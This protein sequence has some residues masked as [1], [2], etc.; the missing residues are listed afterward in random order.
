[1]KNSELSMKSIFDYRTTINNVLPIHNKKKKELEQANKKLVSL[2]ENL[3][4]HEKVREVYQQAALATQ[5]FIET[6]ISSIVTNAI[7]S[8]F[9][10]KNLE[11]KVEFDK[12]RNSTECSLTLL[13][14]GE[15]YEILDDKGFG[16]ADIT[17][18]ALRVAYILLDTVDNVLIMDEP[19]RHLDSDRMSYAS[20]MIAELSKE[21][22]MQFII[23]THSNELDNYADKAIKVVYEKGASK[24]IS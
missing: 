14:D 16:V 11:F 18:F 8:V 12:K 5:R 15:E 13:E 21:L 17:S 22:N 9:F 20:K 10:E 2:E 7:Q 19:L 3:T 24:V 23:V 6:H 4:D 1:M